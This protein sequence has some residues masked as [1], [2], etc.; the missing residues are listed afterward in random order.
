MRTLIPTLCILCILST[1]ALFAQTAE[2]KIP[3]SFY[4]SGTVNDILENEG[5][6]EL[7]IY[8]A[9]HIDGETLSTMIIGVDKDGN[10][11]YANTPKFKYQ[12]F[13]GIA[14]NRAVIDPL[15]STNARV[16]CSAYSAART[17]FV[18]DIKKEEVPA[19]GS[20][21]T[22]YIISVTTTDGQNNFEII[23]GKISNNAGE[24]VGPAVE[25]DPCPTFCGGGY[26]CS[27]N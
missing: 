13:E 18:V 21:C 5:C 19:C 22:G 27:P 7:R 14:N 6:V 11:I 3:D 26:L 8:P 2:P 1:S 12:L 16:A 9:I 17:Y 23:P 25:G 20:G 24:P 15:N 10:D 4:P